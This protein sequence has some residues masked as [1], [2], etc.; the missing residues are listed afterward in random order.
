MDQTF[1]FTFEG[2]PPQTLHVHLDTDTDIILDALRT[3]SETTTSIGDSMAVDLAQLRTAVENT[4]SVEQSAI[5]LIQQIADQLRTMAENNVDPAALQALADQ[6]TSDSDALSA[7]V[8]ANTAPTPTPPGGQTPT[9]I[10][11]R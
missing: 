5:V 2:Y 8:V 1:H 6:L 11:N 7:A 4:R 3:L 9:Q 10:R